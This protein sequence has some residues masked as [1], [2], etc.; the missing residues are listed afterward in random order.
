MTLSLL[1]EKHKIA[2]ADIFEATT[3]NT[4]DDRKSI[5]E[6][7]KFDQEG[8]LIERRFVYKNKTPKMIERYDY[9]IGVVH[10]SFYELGRQTVRFTLPL[11]SEQELRTKYTPIKERIQLL[12][13]APEQITK[14]YAYIKSTD[15]FGEIEQETWHNCDSFSKENEITSVKNTVYDEHGNK[16]ISEEYDSYRKENYI[17]YNIFDA[18]GNNIFSGGGIHTNTIDGIG[19]SLFYKN[20]RIEHILNPYRNNGISVTHYP[21]KRN[22]KV[23]D[24]ICP[25][26]EYD[27]DEEEKDT[28][29]ILDPT[30]RVLKKTVI[31]Y[32]KNEKGEKKKVGTYEKEYTYNE[33]GVLIKETESYVCHNAFFCTS[34]YASETIL[35]NEQ[36]QKIEC[37]EKNP[38][39]DTITIFD[40]TGRVLKETVI[41]YVVNE[42]GEKKKVSTYEKEYT[43]NESG[44]LIK[45]TENNA[46]F[47]ISS[48]DSETI[49]YNDQGQKIE[50]SKKEVCE[51]NLI[52]LD[53]IIIKDQIILEKSLYY[54]NEQGDLI[55]EELKKWRTDEG[56]ET[57][58]ELL[59]THHFYEREEEYEAHLKVT[60]KTK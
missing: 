7:K 53:P 27:K 32:E 59:T 22:K 48:Y 39:E 20:Q 34:S 37:N 2:F 40:P 6:E 45:E 11:Y 36:G 25:T 4:P 28:I 55:R 30:G 58:V 24:E 33:S 43:Y 46:L 56:I 15:K 10:K 9:E 42:K 3:Y 8:R 52:S 23:Y 44:V 5:L 17:D 19:I 49:L 29:T 26:V 18:Q 60:V 51:R 21:Y 14:V 13:F 12:G 50:H 41:N 57:D 47:C 1:S 35:Y 38:E 16:C 31:D 54:Y